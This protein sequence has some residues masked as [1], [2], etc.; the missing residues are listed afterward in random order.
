MTL[1]GKTIFLTGGR[2]L[3]GSAV[4]AHLL[5]VADVKLNTVASE[6]HDLT[7]PDEAKLLVD[8]IE[9]DIVIHCAGR[10][11]GIQANGADPYRYGRENLL[12]GISVLDA[13]IAAKKQPKL[14]V[15]GSTCSF[16]SECPVPFK[17]ENLWDGAPDESN[18]PYGSAKRELLTLL[19]AAVRG[20]QLEHAAYII[21]ANLFGGAADSF[22]EDKSHVIPALVKRFCQAA[23]EN[24][25]VVTCWGTGDATRDF[26][27]VSD[28][29]AG[30]VRVCQ[31]GHYASC[32]AVFESIW[33]ANPINLGTG[34][35]T[36]I[37]Y[38][39][40]VIARFA[41]YRGKIEWDTSKPDGQ[42]RRCLDW[43]RANEW[44]GWRPKVR[45]EDGLKEVVEWWKT[46]RKES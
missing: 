16:P 3:M 22:G 39:A 12:M 32:G 2:G 13:C 24:A 27:H 31:S 21:P 7:D 37:A 14:I 36:S 28:A 35:E 45:L 34:R 30:I 11:G 40:E 19:Q 17:E 38:L 29:A 20:G 4:A 42:K 6:D 41:G 8:D 5:Q 10:V 9:P 33:R 23:E 44:L 26:L 18:R 46:Q 43:D 25:P 15:A 1:S